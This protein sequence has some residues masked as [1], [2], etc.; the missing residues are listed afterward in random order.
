[1]IHCEKKRPNTI[2]FCLQIKHFT[3]YLCHVYW[4]CS[5]WLTSIAANTAWIFFFRI[6]H[7]TLHE[8][9][10]VSNQAAIIILY[11]AYSDYNGV[12]KLAIKRGKNVV[13]V[14]RK[15]ELVPSE[16]PLLGEVQIDQG[17]NPLIALSNHPLFTCFGNGYH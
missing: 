5:D 7:L 15:Q 6:N 11:L 14:Q 4:F 1:M 9:L 13:G 3:S 10:M 17:C 16:N 8:L 12:K 2:S